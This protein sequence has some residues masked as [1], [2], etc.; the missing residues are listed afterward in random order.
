MGQAKQ[1]GSFEHR[2]SQSIAQQK[3]DFDSQLERRM[4]M[5]AAKPASPFI[6]DDELSLMDG[7]RIG[8]AKGAGGFTRANRMA[9]HDAM[10]VIPAGNGVNDG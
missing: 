5:A 7:G 1:R 8:V 6:V 3:A 9:L 2:K 10:Y 4:G